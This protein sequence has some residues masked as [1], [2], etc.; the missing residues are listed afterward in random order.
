VRWQVGIGGIGFEQVLL[1]AVEFR[2]VFAGGQLYH[3]IGLHVE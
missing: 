2:F 1:E 3:I